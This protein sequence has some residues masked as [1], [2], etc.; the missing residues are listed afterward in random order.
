MLWTNR[1]KFLLFDWVFSGESLPDNFYVALVTADNVPTVDTNTLSEL[2]EIADGNGYTEG[3]YELTPGTP[4]FDIII[5]DDVNNLARIQIKDILWTATGG[6]IPAS[7]N[8]ARYVVLTDD[9]E[10][11]AAALGDRQIIAVWDMVTDRVATNGFPISLTNLELRTVGLDGATGTDS[12][13]EGEDAA[14]P[15][16]Y[17]GDAY[18]GYDGP[19]DFTVLP[20]EALWLFE[21]GSMLLDETDNNND[22]VLYSEDPSFPIVVDTAAKIEG[23]SSLKLYSYYGQF[24]NP[25]VRIQ[26]VALSADFPY[27]TDRANDEFTICFW[28]KHH[29]VWNAAGASWEDEYW[30]KSY[31]FRKYVSSYVHFGLHMEWWDDGDVKGEL[32]FIYYTDEGGNT[33]Q[34][35][36]FQNFVPDKWYHVAVTYKPGEYR[37]RVFDNDAAAQLGV[38]V[39]GVAGTI[40]ENAGYLQLYQGRTSGTNST[41]W[42]DEMVVF[43]RVLSVADI[44]KVRAGTYG[45]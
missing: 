11:S 24:A 17:S 5:E 26:D 39:T 41:T 2:T 36:K 35:H 18:P 7:G 12:I 45:T 1:G 40:K 44:D 37:I 43:N 13:T 14:P 30:S 16:P 19:N 21:T 29:D 22:W 4:D 20:P 32:R 6:T 25:Q 31:L 34:Y 3:G 38:D 42:I 10:S 8:G 23:V 28:M 9:S 27:K 15:P 33:E